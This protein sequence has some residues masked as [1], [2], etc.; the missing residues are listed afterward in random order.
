[1]CPWDQEVQPETAVYFVRYWRD[2][3]PFSTHRANAQGC[4]GNA[5]STCST[6]Q[7]VRYCKTTAVYG[8]AVDAA[9]A[10]LQYLV[11]LRRMSRKNIAT[12]VQWLRCGTRNRFNIEASVAQHKNIRRIQWLCSTIRWFADVLPNKCSGCA[13]VVHCNEEESRDSKVWWCGR[14]QR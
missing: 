5:G 10:Q 1:M 13:A 14:A 6:M 12:E 3:S 8:C 7:Q 11:Q 2:T 9:L 4:N